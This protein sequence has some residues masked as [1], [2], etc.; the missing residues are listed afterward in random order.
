MVGGEVGEDRQTSQEKC[1]LQLETTGA[2][3]Q[4]LRIA[5][6]GRKT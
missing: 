6:I 4:G 1:S 2:D 5:M 3:N